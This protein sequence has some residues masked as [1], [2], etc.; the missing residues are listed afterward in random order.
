M[1]AYTQ[2]LRFDDDGDRKV[3]VAEYLKRTRH[4]IQPSDDDQYLDM[5]DLDPDRDGHLTVAEVRDTASRAFRAV[6]TNIDGV[7]SQEEIYRRQGPTE[8]GGAR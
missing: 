3:T 2:V 7:I 8:N 6:D 4:Y 1:Q 5:L